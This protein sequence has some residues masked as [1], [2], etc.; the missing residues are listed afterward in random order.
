[1]GAERERE[2]ERNESSMQYVGCTA[3]PEESGASNGP[4]PTIPA[5]SLLSLSLVFFFF[6]LWGML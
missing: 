5:L 3:H 2:R 1:M 4:S 6:L